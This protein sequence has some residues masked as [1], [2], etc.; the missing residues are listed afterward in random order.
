VVQFE[1]LREIHKDVSAWCALQHYDVL[2]SMVKP[3][4]KPPKQAKAKKSPKKPV[5]RGGFQS[6]RGA[7]RERSHTELVLK[8]Q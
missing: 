7:D 1:S 2:Q 5:S 4:K 3:K 6:G 8:G